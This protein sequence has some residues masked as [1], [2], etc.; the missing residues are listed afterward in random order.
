MSQYSNSL[1]V[2]NDWTLPLKG[3]W[4]SYNN[5][6][7]GGR[8]FDSMFDPPL[9]IGGDAAITSS[10][11]PIVSVSGKTDYWTVTILDSKNRLWG[12]EQGASL[13]I[14]HQ[15][16]NIEITFITTPGQPIQYAV[17]TWPNGDSSKLPVER[18]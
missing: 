16:G 10:N 4:I 12:T 14:P 17:F 7:T 8:L 18:I 13:N 5:S 9:L 6:G 15:S 1:S 11:E 2:D 3:V